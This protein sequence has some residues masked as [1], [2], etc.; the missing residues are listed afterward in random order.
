MTSSPLGI[1]CV[2]VESG[3]GLPEA[4]EISGPAQGLPVGSVS[5]LSVLAKSWLPVYPYSCRQRMLISASLST[6]KE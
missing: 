4:P 5:A 3:V 6:V 2:F 1:Q